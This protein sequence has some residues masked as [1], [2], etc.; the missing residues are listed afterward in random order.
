[1]LAIAAARLGFAPVAAVDHDPA[2]VEATARNA[3]RN[4]VDVD[5]RLIDASAPDATL[6]P[7]RYAVANISLDAVTTTGPVLACERLIASGYLAS[8]EPVVPGFARL[9]R[10]SAEGWAADLFERE[11]Q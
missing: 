2:A 6:P 8:E 5:V 7:A 11:T 10:R 4:G 1:V 3:E 9:E